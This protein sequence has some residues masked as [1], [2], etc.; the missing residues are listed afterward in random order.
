MYEDIAE[1]QHPSA[2]NELSDLMS[3][4][5]ERSNTVAE[6]I[7]RKLAP[8]MLQP[9]PESPSDPV[10]DGREYP[11]LFKDMKDKLSVIAN[12]FDRIQES[13]DRTAL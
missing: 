4:L 10:K 11:P 1:P 7:D 13:L 8:I 2:A 12:S 5:V 6:N 9:C 3:S